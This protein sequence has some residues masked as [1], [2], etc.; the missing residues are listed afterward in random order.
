M[1]S[2]IASLQLSSRSI[3]LLE[4]RVHE[5]GKDL[6]LTGPL[7]G[8]SVTP[9][10]QYEEASRLA[11]MCRTGVQRPTALAHQIAQTI[12]PKRDSW[13]ESLPKGAVPQPGLATAAF[14][15]ASL[16]WSLA[17]PAAAEGAH[18]AAALAE[19]CDQIRTQ[20]QHAFRS[21]H[22]RRTFEGWAT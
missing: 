15:E 14:G 16:K 21:Q 17:A 6:G 3:S 9:V 7:I 8:A 19:A 22:Q 4:S 11:A 13:P 5:T 2:P 18:N 12:Q 10:F 1:G 20:R